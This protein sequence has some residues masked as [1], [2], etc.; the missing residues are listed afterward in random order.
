MQATSGVYLGSIGS[1]N[2]VSVVLTKYFCGISSSINS[3]LWL[4]IKVA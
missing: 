1:K 3:I 4:F 2:K